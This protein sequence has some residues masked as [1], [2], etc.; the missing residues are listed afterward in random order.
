M[1]NSVRKINVV[2]VGIVLAIALSVAFLSG[3][4][5]SAVGTWYQESGYSATLEITEDSFVLKTDGETIEEGSVRLDDDVCYLTT[6]GGAEF[7]YGLSSDGKTLTCSTQST[8]VIAG[9]WHSS[10]ADAASHPRSY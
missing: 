6:S 7:K 5:K 8:L 1:G 2:L 4:S 3:C 9:I 10:E